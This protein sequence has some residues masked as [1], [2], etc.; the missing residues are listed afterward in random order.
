M[1]SRSKRFS[2]IR[3]FDGPDRFWVASFTR[4]DLDHLVDMTELD[5]S[6]EDH[7]FRP[8]V[9]ICKHMQAVLDQLNDIEPPIHSPASR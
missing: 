6:C 3:V 2:R 5:C 1:R 4:G 8:E 7:H 9:L